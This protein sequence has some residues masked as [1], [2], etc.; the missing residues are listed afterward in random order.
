M[1]DA[2]RRERDRNIASK[3]GI[4]ALGNA[5]GPLR[6]AV[7]FASVPRN[8]LIQKGLERWNAGNAKTRNFGTADM[9]G[10]GR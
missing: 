2:R 7:M 9:C 4:S 1:L 6:N 8:A 3:A 5:A 10:Y